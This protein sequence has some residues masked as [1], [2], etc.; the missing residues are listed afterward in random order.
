MS[1][2]LREFS[3]SAAEITHALEGYLHPMAIKG[4]ELINIGKYWDAH[5]VLEQAWLAEEG[6]IRALYKGILQLGVMQLQVERGNLYGAYKMFRRSQ[7][8]L[9]PWPDHVRGVAVG[10]FKKDGRRFIKAALKLGE[11]GLANFDPAL[12]FKVQYEA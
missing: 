11:S 2:H 9:E 8:W 3:P 10:K 5:E 12:Y 1:L 4:I 7:V 6:I